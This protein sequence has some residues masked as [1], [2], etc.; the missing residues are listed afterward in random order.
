MLQLNDLTIS[1]AANRLDHASIPF[2]YKIFFL[3]SFFLFSNMIFVRVSNLFHILSSFLT[4]PAQL[5]Y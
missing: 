1:N 5:E 3:F 4:V 2:L